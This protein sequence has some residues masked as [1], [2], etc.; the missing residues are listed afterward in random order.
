MLGVSVQMALR[1]CCK[2][3]RKQQSLLL[4]T[5]TAARVAVPH[6]KPSSVFS[7]DCHIDGKVVEPMEMTSKRQF[8]CIKC[9]VKLVLVGQLEKRFS[10]R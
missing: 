9:K 3:R 6:S 4:L 1:A 8:R 5:K 2:L 7:R 10:A